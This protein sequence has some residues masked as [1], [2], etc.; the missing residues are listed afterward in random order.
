MALFLY[1][2]IALGALMIDAI[3]ELSFITSMVAWL[4]QTASGTFTVNYNDST[5]ELYGM[6]K[7]FLVD[8]GHTSNGA[9]G[10]AI[11][12][13]GFGGIVTL[14]FRNRPHILGQK[15]TSFIYY[16]WLT[17][18]VLGLMLTIGA[19]GYVFAVTNA[20]RGQSI[21]VKVASTTGNH[22][23]PLD[24]WTPQNWFPAMLDLDLANQSQRNDIAA[25]LRIMRG[26]QYNLIPMFLLQLTTTVLAF[27][28]FFERRRTGPSHVAY[29][30][31]ERSSGE[32]KMVSTP[33]A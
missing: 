5:F 2:A 18:L 15:F 12:L 29:G 11:V 7:H 19:L 14:F 10:T 16:L 20:H 25:H 6:P 24:T 1:L 30:A 9:A 28:E 23:Y 8:Q 3:L 4:H 26:W 22:K 32:Q 27:L 31:V 21:D 13:I 17:I 33:P